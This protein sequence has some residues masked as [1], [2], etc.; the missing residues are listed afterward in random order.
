MKSRKTRAKIR[1]K[2][3]PRE[4][5][6]ICP[7]RARKKEFLLT[8]TRARKKKFSPARDLGSKFFVFHA[9]R[10]Q[11]M[12]FPR[13]RAGVCAKL[14]PR[15]KIFFP[16]RAAKNQKFLFFT[17]EQKTPNRNSIFNMPRPRPKINVFPQRPRPNFNFPP[18]REKINFPPRGQKSKMF[19]LT[20]TRARQKNISPP[21]AT[22]G[23]HFVFF[24]SGGCKK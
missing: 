2:L 4:K 12:K 13:A 16:P 7:P 5:S 23:Q 15:D 11:N 10:L 24:E 8:S 9:R 6:K 14:A 18:A 1:A 19:E 20:P 17:R 21:R 22:R 3:A